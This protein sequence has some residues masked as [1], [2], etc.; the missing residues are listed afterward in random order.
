MFLINNQK[1][2]YTSQAINFVIINLIVALISFVRSF[3][4]MNIFDFKELGLITLV[5]T[6]AML[7]SFFQLGLINGGYRI[8]ALGE[9]KS[10][11]KTNNVV[12][13]FFG[14]LTLL[15][16]VVSFAGYISEIF[17]NGFTLFIICSLGVGN[18]ITNWLSN[19]LIGNQD[20]NKL[21]FANI[22]SSIASLLFL[23][24]AYYF[25]I[26]GALVSLLLQ[27]IIFIFI[28]FW[29]SRKLIPIN[30]DLDFD[31]FKYILSFGFIPFLSGI[32][33]LLFQQ[34]ER[35]SID[36]FL[37]SEALGKLYLVYL[38]TTLWILI[39]SS[40]NSLFFPKSIKYFTEK[41]LIQVRKTI[42]QYYII[43]IAYGLIAALIIIL[44][45]PIIVNV[46]FPK[47]A[48]FIELI[49]LLL[50]GLIIR[51]LCDPI[52]LFFNSAV[53][54]KPILASDVISI[55]CYLIS[56]FYLKYFGIFTLEHIIICFGIYNLIKF[57]YLLFNYN[58]IRK[59]YY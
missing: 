43:L 49:Y 50:P 29:K 40:I 11:I 2:R 27:P 1:G 32:F 51:N 5:N 18:L 28:V 59:T 34:I 41:N 55:I 10:S 53:R 35:W 26:Q 57:S 58:I 36:I 52:S 24:L 30:L 8:I 6:A 46:L 44:L 14:L 21:N 19:T 47:H 13:T 48:P 38:L 45:L 23:S 16:V 4:F 7:I 25:G 9:D 12:F 56:I 31:H 39:P 33:F 20:Y 15:L 22:T 37:G 54:F 3:A 42:R 17:S